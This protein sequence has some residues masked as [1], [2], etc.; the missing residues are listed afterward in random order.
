VHQAAGRSGGGAVHGEGESLKKL[1][2]CSSASFYRHAVELEPQLAVQ[3]FEVILPHS[4]RQ[5]QASGDFDL[6]HYQTWHTDAGDYHKKT[7]LMRRHL[8]A[9]GRADAILVINDEKRGVPN[10]IGGNV[11]I[12]MALAFYLK[13]PIFILNDVPK[14]SMF[15]EEIIG[16]EPQCLHGDASDLMKRLQ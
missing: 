7:D 6:S 13:K 4:A 9:V 11:L 3:G 2:V 12:E 5:M 1:T 8:D 16:L 15:E 10:Y 14:S